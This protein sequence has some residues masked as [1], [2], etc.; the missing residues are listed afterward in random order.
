VQGSSLTEPD[1]AAWQWLAWEAL[2]PTAVRIN[3][4]PSATAPRGTGVGSRLSATCAAS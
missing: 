3:L 4:S 1:L 2:L